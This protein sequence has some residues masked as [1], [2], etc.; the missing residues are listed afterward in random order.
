M[1]VIEPPQRRH[2]RRDQLHLIRQ[3][4]VTRAPRPA[5]RHNCAAVTA[6]PRRSV[7][8][9]ATTSGTGARGRN[10]RRTHDYPAVGSSRSRSRP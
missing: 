8:T 6:Y 1:P 4:P 2:M 3:H 7:S 5:S 10:P 9:A